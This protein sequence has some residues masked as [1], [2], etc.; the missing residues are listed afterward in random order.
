MPTRKPRR[1]AAAELLAMTFV[2][3]FNKPFKKGFHPG[4]F[5]VV[6]A[7]A[8][9]YTDIKSWPLILCAVSPPEADF[10]TA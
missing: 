6:T 9:L 1:P 5:M 2:M 8:P 10:L 3:F 7:G 4:V